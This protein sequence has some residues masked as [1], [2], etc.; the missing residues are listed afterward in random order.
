VAA[1]DKQ[2]QMRQKADSQPDTLL[3]LLVSIIKGFFRNIPKTILFQLIKFGAVFLVVFILHAYL[4]TVKNE[5]YNV[6]WNNPYAAITKLKGVNYAV[7]AFWGFFS[8]FLTVILSRIIK[9]PGTFIKEIAT[10]P[11]FLF[12]SMK[13]SGEAAPVSIFFGMALALMSYLVIKS[14]YMHILYALLLIMSLT[15]QNKGLL[16]LMLK[17]GWQDWH[18]FFNTKKAGQ[19][20]NNNTVSVFILG[21]AIGLF[22]VYFLPMKPYSPF[23][24]AILLLVLCI[25]IKT[26]KVSPT[27]AMMILT[28]FTFSI[29]IFKG[30][31]VF[32]DDVGWSEGGSTLKGLVNSPGFGSALASGLGPSTAAA[33]GTLAGSFVPEIDVT[34]DGLDNGEYG[35]PQDGAGG[36]GSAGGAAEHDA[37]TENQQDG[38]KDESNEQTPETGIPIINDPLGGPEDNPYT[39][40]D[41]ENPCV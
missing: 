39:T 25:L 38:S 34:D 2:S 4:L 23:I 11:V 22:I 13:E 21:L 33:G 1:F 7:S 36:V 10:T 6:D 41:G 3:R 20:A 27:A 29:I 17:L 28:F 14:P 12:R 5:G 32:A 37:D 15:K 31:H 8:F 35:A 16:L 18:R 26:K 40:F 9:G 30:Q 19:K 24:L